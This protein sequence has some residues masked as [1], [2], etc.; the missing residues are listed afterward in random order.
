[1]TDR[2]ITFTRL[3]IYTL[4]FEQFKENMEDS[5]PELTKK[6]VKAIWMQMLEDTDGRVDNEDYDGD[7]D[8]FEGTICNVKDDAMNELKIKTD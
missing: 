1:M 7:Y 2:E 5:N 4:D 3:T 8:E 6:Q